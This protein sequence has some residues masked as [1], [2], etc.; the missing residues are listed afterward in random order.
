MLVA[1]VVVDTTSFVICCLLVLGLYLLKE[2]SSV[3]ATARIC[4]AQSCCVRDVS[5]KLHAATF[6]C[7]KLIIWK[8]QQ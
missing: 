8:A 6:E 2:A 1:Y 3:C 4:D 7:L 5:P